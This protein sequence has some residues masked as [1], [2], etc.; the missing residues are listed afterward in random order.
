MGDI[1]LSRTTFVTVVTFLVVVLVLYM[2]FSHITGIVTSSDFEVL[3][4]HEK[5]HICYWKGC[6]N[7]TTITIRSIDEY[8]EIIS[9]EQK[10][11]IGI[12]GGL[13]IFLNP[14]KSI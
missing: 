13:D 9:F 11:S 10:K 14:S 8:E 6:T 2:S 5:I 4:S 3:A 12:E 1:S 7:S